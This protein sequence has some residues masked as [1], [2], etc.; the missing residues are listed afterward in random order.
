MS[1][2]GIEFHEGTATKEDIRA[3][4][5]A[6]DRDFAPNLSLKVNI[7]EY[8][9]KIRTRAKTFEAWSDK[10]L[11]GLVAVYMNDSGT[12]TGFITSVSVAKE[13][14]GRGIASTLLDHC[15]NRLR[16]EG[17][18]VVR[19]EVSSESHEAIRLYKNLGFSEIMC[20]GEIVSM[21]MEISE[22]RQ[23]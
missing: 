11:I 23:S 3:H 22:K 10:V 13:F 2:L 14:M 18:K 7:E 6:C 12:R 16:Q 15:L 8:S 21:E 9:T 20:K 17:M 5:Q 19:L 1:C 4:L